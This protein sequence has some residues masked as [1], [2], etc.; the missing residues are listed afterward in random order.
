MRSGRT[1]A[2]VVVAA[3]LLHVSTSEA[4]A[5]VE[6]S[7]AASVVNISGG[8]FGLGGRI[9][10]PVRQSP[11]FTV[12]LE[13][14]IDYYFPDCAVDCDLVGGQLDVVFQDRLGWRALVYYGLGASFQHATL[15]NDSGVIAEGDYW[16]F[17]VLAGGRY[18]PEASV[19]PFI[20]IRWTGLEEI[21]NQFALTLGATLIAGG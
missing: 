12:R 6:L 3:A 16:G 20:E 18:N 21:K 19:Q 17:N 4:R 13:A 9:G 10:V 14:G 1:L 2:V 5:Q 15:Q 8:A 7:G 11:Q